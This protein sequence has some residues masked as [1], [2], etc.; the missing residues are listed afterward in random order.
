MYV[1]WQRASALPTWQQTEVPANADLLRISE[2][3]R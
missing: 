2:S 1:S 3:F